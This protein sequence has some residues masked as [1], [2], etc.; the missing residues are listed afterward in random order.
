MLNTNYDMYWDLPNEWSYMFCSE[1]F[2][3]S[4]N[5]RF[6]YEYWKLDDECLLKIFISKCNVILQNVFKTHLRRSKL[7]STGKNSCTSLQ[8]LQACFS[9][10]KI[11]P[12]VNNFWNSFNQPTFSS[13][14]GKTAT[15]PLL[16]SCIRDCSSSC[17]FR[18]KVLKKLKLFSVLLNY[19]N[20]KIQ[21]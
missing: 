14:G 12:L 19:L 11:L 3:V 21:S 8:P 5:T 10:C 17:D 15:F 13:L 20:K 7:F 1:N 18:F 4:G 9:P 2:I 16:S 6:S